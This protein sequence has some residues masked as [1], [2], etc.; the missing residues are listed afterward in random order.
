[1]WRPAIFTT[2]SFAAAIWLG[3]SLRASRWGA[4]LGWIGFVLSAGFTGCVAV[5]LA[6]YLGLSGQQR[7]TIR[8]RVQV[9]LGAAD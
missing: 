3:D 6:Y 4:E 8:R 2:V 5:L 9:L 1:V 7:R